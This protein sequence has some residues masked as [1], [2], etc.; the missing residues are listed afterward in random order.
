[1]HTHTT[2]HLT[3]I[4]S[5]I[6]GVFLCLSYAGETVLW[7]QAPEVWAMLRASESTRLSLICTLLPALSSIAFGFL[8]MCVR[9][10]VPVQVRVHARVRVCSRAHVRARARV[11][12]RS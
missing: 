11:R 8:G 7:T 9:V 6:S 1:M 3:L 12:V 5:L 2:S 4:H 10:R